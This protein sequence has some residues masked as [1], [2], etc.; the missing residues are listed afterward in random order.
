MTFDEAMKAAMQGD[1][2]SRPGK[3]KPKGFQDLAKKVI[4]DEGQFF[5]KHEGESVYFVYFEDEYPEDLVANDW[6]LED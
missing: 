1:I 4:F 5:V 2:V 6:K 3:K